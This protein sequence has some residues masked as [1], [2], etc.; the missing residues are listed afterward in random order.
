MTLLALAQAYV[1][2]ENSVIP[3]E[4]FSLV[5]RSPWE[6]WIQERLAEVEDAAPECVPHAKAALAELIQ[7]ALLCGCS[8]QRMA[9]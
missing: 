2:H 6:R 7:A 4:V 8:E 9:S 1:A 5:P 3:V